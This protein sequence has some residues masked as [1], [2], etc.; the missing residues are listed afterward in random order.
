MGIWHGSTERD[1]EKRERGT[2]CAE[3]MWNAQPAARPDS[4]AARLRT[5]K[6]GR[7]DIWQMGEGG[8]EGTHVLPSYS[9]RLPSCPL[10]LSRAV[11]K[12]I[13]QR[14]TDGEKR[15]RVEIEKGGRAK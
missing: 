4:P 5:L 12:N 9:P 15:E 2:A 10:R 1:E 7:K 3:E 8:R 6:G 11:V 13:S 14:W